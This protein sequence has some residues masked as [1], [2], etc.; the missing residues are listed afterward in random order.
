MRFQG[1]PEWLTV[2]S[3]ELQPCSPCPQ[4]KPC[5]DCGFVKM[6]YFT[7]EGTDHTSCDECSLRQDDGRRWCSTR[8][9]FVEMTPVIV[10]IDLLANLLFRCECGLKGTLAEVRQHL[11]RDGPH[12]RPGK[13]LFMRELQEIDECT[14]KLERLAV[15]DAARLSLCSSVKLRQ[16]A[17][18]CVAWFDFRV[19]HALF[20]QRGKRTR[21]E[22]V[23]LMIGD[24]PLDVYLVL[25]TTFK[26]DHLTA[27][28]MVSASVKDN[29]LLPLRNELRLTLVEP[30]S[31]T[32]LADE[33]YLKIPDPIGSDIGSLLAAQSAVVSV[34]VLA[35]KLLTKR[36][37]ICVGIE[38]RPI[39]SSRPSSVTN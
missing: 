37:Q 29:V 21:S 4:L 30:E 36:D 39:Q 22:K 28:A 35:K 38:L 9:S 18:S 26:L 31:R 12:S 34:G 6:L 13:T 5:V 32:P 25:D 19:L 11:L 8:R 16:S 17:G 27:V 7:C 33:N 15:Q 14:V 1:L 20:L 10:T 2:G 24:L 23:S 3:R